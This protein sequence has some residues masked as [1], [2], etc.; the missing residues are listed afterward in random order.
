MQVFSLGYQG[1]SLDQYTS[2]LLEVGV[3]MVL[4]VRE[5]PWSYNR[6][7]IRS[8]MEKALNAVGIDYQHLKECGNPSANRKTASSP[9]ECLDR[10]RTL[11]AGEQGCLDRLLSQIAAADSRGRP[12]C[13]TCYEHDPVDCH[14]T[15][16]LEFIAE[17]T[18]DLQ[19]IHLTPNK[20]QSIKIVVAPPVV[21]DTKA[22]QW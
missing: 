13:L 5:T 18:P 7:Y 15:I 12:A 1:L 22:L 17:R 8:V 20:N 9:Q 4:D 14:R 6:R 16:L 11:L 3:G 19:I 10:Y 21:L 2:A